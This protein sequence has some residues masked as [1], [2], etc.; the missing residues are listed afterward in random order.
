MKNQTKQNI[1]ILIIILIIIVPI[2]INETK[3]INDNI[4][5]KNIEKIIS[6]VNQNI[7]DK[8]IDEVI[9][10]QI[11]QGLKKG[12]EVIDLKIVGKGTVFVD[13]N[14]SITIILEYKDKCAVKYSFAEQAII[15]DG[16]CPIYKLI[17][18]AKMEIVNSGDGLYDVGGNK[19]LYR[20]F[21][22]DNYLEYDDK[23]W[24]IMEIGKEGIKLVSDGSISTVSLETT[25]FIEGGAY[26]LL[27]KH[28][29]QLNQDYIKT[30]N[31]KKTELP[32][33]L[34]SIEEVTMAT[35]QKCQV[36]EIIK[37]PVSY[38]GNTSTWLMD[39]GLNNN[40]WYLYND[41]N[42]YFD[43]VSNE[44]NIRAVILLNEEVKIID[45]FGSS[46]DPYQIMKTIQSE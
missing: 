15:G 34:L 14:R 27:L 4:I 26:P 42:I 1:I 37:C 3:S 28:Y 32:I 19:Y 36:E 8:S 24:R 9:E 45:G 30:S 6:I 33:R 10:Y 46:D 18:G 17:K 21:S 7:D 5:N 13:P 39:D 25:N 43:K 29:N 23:L 41:G 38:L 44:K 11:N 20:G 31:W 16:K 12:N 35:L 40:G 22:V 2:I